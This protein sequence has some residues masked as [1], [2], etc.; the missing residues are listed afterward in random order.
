[1]CFEQ[2]GSICSQLDDNLV[3]LHKIK[4]TI[5]VDSAVSNCLFSFA[6]FCIGVAVKMFWVIF[7]SQNVRVNVLRATFIDNPLWLKLCHGFK[8]ALKFVPA[9]SVEIRMRFMTLCLLVIKG[10]MLG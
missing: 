2:N 6:S 9:H 4:T 1:M 10:A 7:S 3:Y 5:S 8:S